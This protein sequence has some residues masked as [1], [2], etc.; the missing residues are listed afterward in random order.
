MSSKFFVRDFPDLDRT[1][2]TPPKSG[3]IAVVLFVATH[4]LWFL[5]S[6]AGLFLS[7]SH[8]LPSQDGVMLASRS[9]R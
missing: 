1:D 8:A 5:L 7:V 2:V 4:G 6:L 9:E 3:R